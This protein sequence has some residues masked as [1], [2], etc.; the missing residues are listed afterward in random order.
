MC[1]GGPVGNFVDA[2]TDAA[3]TAIDTV[4]DNPV[5]TVLTGGLNATIAG[6]SS[7]YDAA[8]GA[9]N[10]EEAQDKLDAAAEIQNVQNEIIR[11]DQLRA[12]IQNNEFRRARQELLLA[13]QGFLGVSSLSLAQQSIASSQ[14]QL[15]QGIAQANFLAGL[16]AEQQG[17]AASAESDLQSAANSQQTFGTV[18]N[19]AG[20][21]A[22]AAFGGGA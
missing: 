17:L 21:A 12:V 19:V 15:A 7:L 14:T 20:T 3:N 2:V 18:L 16:E 4:L 9:E 6:A 8:T 5:E 22:S 10:L 13:G 11:R 1:G